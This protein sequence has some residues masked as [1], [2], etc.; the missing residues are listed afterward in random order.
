MWTGNSLEK[1]GAIENIRQLFSLTHR[2][3]QSLQDAICDR[4]QSQTQSDYK[5]S[6]SLVGDWLASK[7][8][9]VEIQL[10]K[11]KKE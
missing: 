4:P 8:N 6:S 9:L 7:A 11:K 2:L 3:A 10:K 1:E 5:K